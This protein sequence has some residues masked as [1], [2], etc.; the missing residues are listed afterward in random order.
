MESSLIILALG[1]AGVLASAALAGGAVLERRRADLRAR[2]AE[3]ALEARSRYLG[4]LAQEMQGHGMA[5]LGYATAPRQDAGRDSGLEGRARALLGLSADV[6]DL[7]AQGAGPRVLK[8]DAT[9]LGPVLDEVIGHIVQALTPGRRHW[10]VAPDL[11]GLTLSADRR[12]LTGALRQVLTRVVR[13]TRDG[14]SVQ[15]RLVRADESVAIVVED[16][17]TGQAAEDLNGLSLGRG[18]RGLGLGLVVAHDLMRAHGGDLTI[19]AVPGI[20]A[21]AWLTLPRARVLEAAAA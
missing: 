9:P 6:S 7:L 14:D 4:L 19:E 1:G 12:A 13:H 17:G 15:M 18:T 2:A 16:D 20:G 8:E 10:Q 11:R 21:R 3:Q 5:L